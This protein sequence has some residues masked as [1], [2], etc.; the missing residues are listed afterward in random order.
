MPGGRCRAKT[1]FTQDTLT[2]LSKGDS[3]Y[4]KRKQACYQ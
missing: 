1:H 4:D 3:T 2:A